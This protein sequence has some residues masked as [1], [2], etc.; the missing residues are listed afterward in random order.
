MS[1]ESETREIGGRVASGLIQLA[2]ALVAEGHSV[3]I[4]V[5]IQDSDDRPAHISVKLAVSQRL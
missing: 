1:D 2:H 3:Q 5:E 4:S